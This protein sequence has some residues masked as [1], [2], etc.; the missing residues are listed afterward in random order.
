MAIFV[1]RD[2]LGEAASGFHLAANLAS[3]LVVREHETL[4]TANWAALHAP[5]DEALSD[6][7]IPQGMARAHPLVLP[8]I[9]NQEED[10]RDLDQ[11]SRFDMFD[12]QYSTMQ[13]LPDTRYQQPVESGI[14]LGSVGIDPL[15]SGDSPLG[16]IPNSSAPAPVD[17]AQTA[18]AAISVTVLTPRTYQ[19][20]DSP[21]FFEDAINLF[22]KEFNSKYQRP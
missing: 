18:G 3:K 15:S 5:I 20:F 11:N 14:N 10:D 1:L 19:S 13:Y 7:P 6:P 22:D 8:T 4:L 12:S 2:L 17:A 16:P 21:Q 9:N